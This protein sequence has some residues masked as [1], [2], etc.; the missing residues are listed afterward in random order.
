MRKDK[1]LEYRL[2]DSRRAPKL[3]CAFGHHEITY[4]DKSLYKYF[5][6]DII[7]FQGTTGRR[8]VQSIIVCRHCK[9]AGKVTLSGTRGGLETFDIQIE[10][11][12]RE[13]VMSMEITEITSTQSKNVYLLQLEYKKDR[14]IKIKYSLIHHLNNMKTIASQDTKMYIYIT[15]DWRLRITRQY[16]RGLN[17]NGMDIEVQNQLRRDDKKDPSVI[18]KDWHDLSLEVQTYSKYA[19]MVNDIMGPY[20]P[21]KLKYKCEMCGETTPHITLPDDAFTHC[22]ILCTL[23]SYPI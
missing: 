8:H 12:K 15:D 3:S 13:R 17:R 19:Q 22:C 9:S 20:C 14:I 4:K 6:E 21:D 5:K 7:T 1:K 2:K 11:G 16:H 10:K 18:Y 23:L